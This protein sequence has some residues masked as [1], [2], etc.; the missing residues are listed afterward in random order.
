M[1]LREDYL[2][3]KQDLIDIA[4]AIR[5]KKGIKKK[6]KLDEMAKVIEKDDRVLEINDT[7][8]TD[9]DDYQLRKL[10]LENGYQ[11]DEDETEISFE[12]L[13]V[14]C[15]KYKAFYPI[16][17]S[18][19]L[20]S[21]VYLTSLKLGSIEK[22]DEQACYNCVNLISVNAENVIEI[23]ARA[24]Y[25]GTMQ[26][27]QLQD[28]IAPKLE[29]IGDWAFYA[30]KLNKGPQ[31]SNF[32]FENVKEI[33]EFAFANSRITEVYAPRLEKIGMKAF[34]SC[35]SLGKVTLSA[36]KEITVDSFQGATLSD[37]YLLGTH[38]CSLNQSFSS[39]LKV[40]VRKELIDIYKND[41]IWNKSIILPLPEEVS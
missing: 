20:P 31:L 32:S 13:P 1:S 18:T 9:S 14:T 3:L 39:S 15:L 38:F 23:G 24:F 16:S 10:M 17:N 26:A 34:S 27:S 12:G 41:P 5:A 28:F 6:M 21:N 19:S 7:S 35:Y 11:T 4:D 29:K 30:S 8:N 40:Y 25:N 36:I 22:I 37:L 2:T 33:G